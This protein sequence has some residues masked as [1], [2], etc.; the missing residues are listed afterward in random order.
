MN[1]V[2][3]GMKYDRAQFLWILL[4][5]LLGSLSGVPWALAVLG[6]SR[7]AWLEAGVSMLML[8]PASAVGVWLGRKV[9]L[10]SGLR[11]LV[12][13]TPDGWKQVRAGLV[14]ALWAGVSLGTLGLVGQSAVSANALIPGMNNPSILEW[15]LRCLSAGLTEEI[16][17]RFGLMTFLAW[18]ILS[19]AGKPAVHGPSL[20]LG[21]LLSS[22]VFAAAH[23]PSLDI[24]HA[25]PGILVLTLV[26]SA[27]AG[28]LMG[29]VFM[30][31]GL[32]SAIAA[33]CVADLVAHV[34]PRVAA[35]MA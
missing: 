27:G 17:F 11:E 12:S 31:Y 26:T 1:G 10:D 5:G 23:L 14:P 24:Q 33:H 32:V 34:F 9:G 18:A 15:F 29:W 22:L 6:I 3:A 4:A 8:I 19:L 30:R 21:N 25:G 35:A 7:T 28:M 13:R 20:W 16:A 2:V